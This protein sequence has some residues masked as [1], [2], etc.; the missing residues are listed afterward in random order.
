MIFKKNLP[1]IQFFCANQ[2]HQIKIAGQVFKMGSTK[3]NVK[4]QCRNNR[5]SD[6]ALKKTCAWE[7]KGQPW[8]ISD[9]QDVECNFKF[10]ETTTTTTTTTTTSANT[11]STTVMPPPPCLV[12][13]RVQTN[14]DCQGNDIQMGIPLDGDNHLACEDLC[15]ETENCVG[16]TWH[17]RTSKWSEC[18]L[19]NKMGNCKP[20]ESG[21]CNK[22]S[23]ITGFLNN[24]GLC[25][26]PSLRNLYTVKTNYDCTGG[27]IFSVDI[28]LYGKTDERCQEMCETYSNCM[29]YTWSSLDSETSSCH[30]KNEMVKCRPVPAGQCGG[31]N[32]SWKRTCY[33]AWRLSK[34]TP[35]IA[36][37]GKFEVFTHTD[38]P[39]NDIT[40]IFLAGGDHTGLNAKRLTFLSAWKQMCSRAARFR[41]MSSS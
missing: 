25:K 29:G 9:V 2:A 30:L 15:R 4:C 39:G 5:N 11:I 14:Y 40:Q 19:K 3:Q 27:D 28:P 37:D 10:T 1:V 16:Y 38:C 21:T 20:K 26:G 36:C 8:S 33:T 17:G 18:W 7:F 41:K 24:H 23:C 12:T 32:G 34:A 22:G 35:P 31:P 6:L 13:Y